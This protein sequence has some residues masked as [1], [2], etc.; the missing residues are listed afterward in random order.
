MLRL[1]LRGTNGIPT[2]I[3]QLGVSEPGAHEFAFEMPQLDLPCLTRS[4]PKEKLMISACRTASVFM[5]L[6]LLA[7]IGCGS[8][9][10]TGGAGGGPGTG[11]VGG[12][13]PSKDAGVVSSGGVGTGGLGSG[14][15]GSGGR[16]S[17]PVQL[18]H[19]RRLG[20][21]FLARRRQY[22][23]NSCARRASLRRSARRRTL[24]GAR[25]AIKTGRVHSHAPAP[26]GEKSPIRG[27]R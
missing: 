15:V 20:R 9:T 18:A 27:R 8:N 10:S 23:R 17:G 5:S 13:G 11:G 19:L 12:S 25:W 22:A 7:T 26:V 24:S 21:F 1:N 2:R 3:H 16:G 6:V 14:G 4:S